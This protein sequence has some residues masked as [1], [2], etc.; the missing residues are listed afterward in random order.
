MEAQ[1][2]PKRTEQTDRWSPPLATVA[3]F[4]VTVAVCG[5]RLSSPPLV[6]PDEARYAAVGQAMWASGD[7]VTPRLNGFVYLDKPPLLHWLTALS[8][9]LF[10][11]HEFAVRLSSLLAAAVGVALTYAFARRVFGHHAGI[12]SA[13]VLGTSVLWFAV[14]RVIRYD[15]LL[16]VAVTA[17]IW[18][19]WL[20]SEGGEGSRR[21]YYLAAVAAGL[22]VLVKG[23]IALVL[24]VLV[25]LPYLALTRRLRVLAEVPWVAVLGILAAVIVPWF[26]LCEHANPGAIRFF[27]LHENVARMRGEIDEAHQQPWWFLGPILLGA[28]W[29]WTLFFPGAVID[30]FGGRRH[31]EELQRRACILWLLWVAVPLALFSLSKVKVETYILPCLPPV[32]LLIGRYVSPARG[33]GL[34]AAIGTGILLNGVAAAVV[35]VKLGQSLPVAAKPVA[36]I[37][38]LA[39]LEVIAAAILRARKWA[40]ALLAISLLASYHVLLWSAGRDP[41]FPSDKALAAKVAQLRRPGE[42]ILSVRQLSRGA[43]FYLDER[44]AVFGNVPGEYEFS[45]NAAGLRGWVYPMEDAE[46]VL[47]PGPTAVII[48]RRPHW[49]EFEAAAHGLVTT[50]GETDRALILRSEP[51]PARDVHAGEAPP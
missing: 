17:T 12:A 3:V 16:T 32:A 39:G 48:C 7:F 13:A 19:A 40:V 34:W 47:A 35:F 11:P 5:L 49:P 36:L 45:G 2:P 1:L 28:C 20:G 8:I 38:A 31:G 51:R 33:R 21:H 46:R 44:V 15:M 24:P 50:I 43:V 22:G 14:G 42:R 23:P 30:G 18:W 41:R 4:L 9:G 25:I 26:A 29:P 6:E 10:G 37:W 27:L